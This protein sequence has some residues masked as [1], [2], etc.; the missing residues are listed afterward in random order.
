M[1]VGYKYIRWKNGKIQ[2]FV[3]YADLILTFDRR[4]LVFYS[5]GKHVVTIRQKKEEEQEETNNSTIQKE[6]FILTESIVVLHLLV[7]APNSFYT[8]LLQFV[9]CVR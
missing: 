5:N 3:L 4:F 7:P 1:E 8:K 2:R 6:I 9:A